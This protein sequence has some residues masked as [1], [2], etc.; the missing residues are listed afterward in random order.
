MFNV[1]NYWK[2]CVYVDMYVCMYVCTSEA[3][4]SVS[5]EVVRV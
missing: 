1:R 3:A 2:E 4:N 5:G